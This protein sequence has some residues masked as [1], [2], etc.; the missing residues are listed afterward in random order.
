ML[1]SNRDIDKDVCH[2][3]EAGWMKW[4]QVSGILCEKKVPQ[5]IKVKFYRMAIRVEMLYIAEC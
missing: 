5:K 1:Q 3:I 4:Q 2:K